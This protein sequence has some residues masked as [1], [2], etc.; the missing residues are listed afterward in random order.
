ML[1]AFVGDSPEGSRPGSR[2]SPRWLRQYHDGGPVSPGKDGYERSTSDAGTPAPL[3]N[4]EATSTATPVLD[5]GALDKMLA[6]AEMMASARITIPQHLRGRTGD[7]MAVIPQ[8]M[9]WRIN[10][11]ALAQKTHE[12]LRKPLAAPRSWH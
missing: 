9:Q 4:G 5:G 3:S 2:A 8:A 10:P 12:W 7:C 1:S 6:A 11:F